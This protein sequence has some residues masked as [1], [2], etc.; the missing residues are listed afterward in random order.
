MFSFT[1]L[2]DIEI[3]DDKTVGQPAW[4]SA[5]FIPNDQNYTNGNAFAI[6]LNLGDNT[7][8][9]NITYIDN[10]ISCD[11][12]TWIDGN[13]YTSSNNTATYTFQNSAGCDN[14]VTL[15]LTITNAIGTD[16]KTSCGSYTWIDGNTYT[17]SNNTATDTLINAASCDSIVTLNLTINPN[18]FGT[19][20]AASQLLFTSL[21]F[22]GQF[23]NNT[24]NP[25]NY[26]FTWDFG[27]GTIL[28]SNN[29]NVFHDFLYNGQYS[30]ILIAED[31]NTGCTDTMYKQD[32]VSTSGGNTN[33]NNTG[34]DIQNTCGSFT[35]I[36]GNTY[37]SSNNTATFTLT[38]ASGCDSV[39][40][41]NLTIK[42]DSYSVDNQSLCGGSFSWIDG[43]TYTSSNNTATDTL[44][45]AAGCDSIVTLNLTVSS[46]TSSLLTLSSCNSYIYNGQTLNSS[47]VYVAIDTNAAGCLNYDSL[48]LTITTGATTTTQASCDSFLWNGTTYNSSGIYTSNSS[49]N[50]VDTLVLTVFEFITDFSES[51]SLFTAPPF[52]VQFTNTT[53]NLSNYNFTWD[54][55]D[56]TI[57]QT[58]NP[59]VFHQYMY[60]GLYDVKLIAEDIANGCGN[61]TLKKDGLI[62]CSGGPGLSINEKTSLVNIYPNPTNQ[63]ITI[64][65]ENYNGNTQ[66]EVYDLIGNRLQ[67]S[68]ET[69]ISLK[70]YARGIYL[71]KVA[72]GNKLQE[73]KVIKQ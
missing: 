60:N 68:N 26:N 10:K 8:C 36:N 67:I 7:I 59:S 55:G 69:T 61:D 29:A 49:G 9:N 20:F 43:N 71:L 52:S 17:S 11:S 50:C 48:D 24:P 45:N 15:N 53:P 41:L 65:I 28:Q 73:V 4:S 30:V 72:Y 25:S 46:S 12:Y 40:T 39:V 21:P 58:N 70:D 64:S 42:Q 6:R 19:D 44:T 33:C 31:I 14:I 1:N 47:G 18:Q 32:Y 5:I 35:W 27:D 34:T 54:F 23:T 51:N 57:V 56:N 63:N 38:N 16:Y 22:V 3:M 2:Y 62:F 37:T 13:T 66:T